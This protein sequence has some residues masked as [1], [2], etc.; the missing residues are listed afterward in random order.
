MMMILIQQTPCASTALGR[1]TS[2]PNSQLF[3]RQGF[4]LSTAGIL[5]H[6]EDNSKWDWP[7]CCVLTRTNTNFRTDVRY[8]YPARSVHTGSLQWECGRT[9][10][11]FEGTCHACEFQAVS[12]LLLCGLIYMLDVKFLKYN[13]QNCKSS[14]YNIPHTIQ[15]PWGGLQNDYDINKHCLR[16]HFWKPSL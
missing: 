10:A 8:G 2:V 9:R 6:R 1:H 15:R 3:W 14:P 11:A 4:I 7:R 16:K 5:N 13:V 12:D